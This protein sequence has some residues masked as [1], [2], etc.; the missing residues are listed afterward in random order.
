M[1]VF[2][3]LNL[4]IKC[5]NPL[6]NH[7]ILQE[8]CGNGF[9]IIT[10]FLM[11]WYIPMLTLYHLENS[12]SIRILWALEELGVDYQVEYFQRLPN[13]AAPP[14]LQ[15]IHPLGKAPILS[16]HDLVIAESAVILEYL[17]ENYDQEQ[18]F[19][20]QDRL[21]RLQY[22]YWMHY[23]EGSLMPLVVFKLVMGHLGGKNIPL[24]A[25]PLSKQVGIQVKQRFIQPRLMQHLEFI[26]K[27]LAKQLYFAGSEFS[28]A[29]IQ[30]M[31]ALLGLEKLSSVLQD[32]P[33]IQGY[34]QQLRARPAFKMAQ[35]KSPDG[36]KV[37]S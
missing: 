22:R 36:D 5:K 24:L 8:S 21:E 30:M 7:N 37:A 17:Q 23:A 35:H 19:A 12:R 6:Q 16:D 25:R 4:Y 1:R 18:R 9:K 13:M 27:H 11:I 20:P 10:R 33:Y 32:F 34:M 31:F 2:Y 3:F 28:F 15:K 26:E 29:D 14:E